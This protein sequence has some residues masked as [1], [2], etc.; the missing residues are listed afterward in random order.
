MF[1]NLHQ[2]T[3]FF[4]SLILSEHLNTHYIAFCSVKHQFI[5]R[6]FVSAIQKTCELVFSYYR[7]SSLN[8]SYF[9]YKSI[10]CMGAVGYCRR[11]FHDTLR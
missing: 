11:D 9:A 1:S 4:F 3:N 7:Y 6:I 2:K 10:N 8:S 5:Y